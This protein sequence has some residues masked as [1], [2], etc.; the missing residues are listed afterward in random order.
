MQ[1]SVGLWSVGHLRLCG[2][3]MQV[4]LRLYTSVVALVVVQHA[5][6]YVGK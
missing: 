2:V 4:A 6:G 1:F 5:C 3:R